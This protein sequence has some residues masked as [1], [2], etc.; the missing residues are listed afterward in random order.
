VN[1]IVNLPHKFCHDSRRTRGLLFVPRHHLI[2]AYCCAGHDFEGKNVKSRTQS[3]FALLRSARLLLMGMACVCV[4]VSAAHAAE[5][6]PS[7]QPSQKAAKSTKP[8][9]ILLANVLSEH[10]D[11]T[12]Y[13]VSEKYD[14]V[15]AIWDG[16]TLRFRS[17]NVVNAP[18][19]FLDALPKVPLD[20]ELWIQRGKFELLSGIARKSVPEDAEWREVKYMIFELPKAAGSFEAR[21]TKIRELVAVNQKNAPFLRAVEQVR[22]ADRK[23]LKR[24]LDEVVKQR[25][26]GLMLHLADAT[27]VTGRSDVLLKLKPALDTEAIVIAHIAGK[28]KY[29]GMMGALE[30]K[31][32]EG[33][34]FRIGTGFSDAERKNPP[35]VG[36]RI[37]YTY[38]DVT[39]NGVPRFASF[40][41][42]REDP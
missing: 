35:P 27:Y 11:V 34:V 29:A 37:T 28:G 16:D 14:G 41:R 12:Q 15:R 32:P 9:A 7:S 30:V 22:V 6:A 8:P 26:E 42:V 17:G 31:T 5:T 4:C 24:K 39:K 23:A 20:G 33:I 18:R 40:L 19:W 38:R 1:G 36:T 3:G 21:V 2:A 13:L 25:G 10:I